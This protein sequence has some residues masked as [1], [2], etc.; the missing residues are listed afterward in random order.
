[1]KMYRDRIVRGMQAVAVLWALCAVGAAQTEVTGTCSGAAS[2]FNPCVSLEF[3]HPPEIALAETVVFAPVA[4]RGC[5]EAVVRSMSSQFAENSVEVIDSNALALEVAARGV[6]L[7]AFIDAPRAIEVAKILGPGVMLLVREDRCTTGQREYVETERRSRDASET[8]TLREDSRERT[9]SRTERSDSRTETTR[10]ESRTREE[11]AKEE[12][13]DTET[14]GEDTYEVR[15]YFAETEAFVRVSIQAV[16]LASGRIFPA[17]TLESSHSESNESE[18][19]VPRHPSENEVIELAAEQLARQTSPWFQP[20]QETRD[21]L[22]FDSDSKQCKLKAAARAFRRK[23]FELAFDLAKENVQA[24]MASSNRRFQSNAHYNLGAVHRA[25]E[26]YDLALE[27]FRTAIDLNPE[28]TIIRDAVAE[29]TATVRDR[30]ALAEPETLPRTTLP[31]NVSVSQPG[32]TPLV[33]SEPVVQQALSNAD[34]IELRKRGIPSVIIISRIKTATNW[35]FDLSATALDE[36][37]DAEVGEDVIT[38]M[39]EKDSQGPR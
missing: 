25:R 15:V 32:A 14:D 20:F 22:V 6:S 21:Y 26:E 18:R 31:L 1:M 9:S 17:K 39:M 2:A 34:V 3:E 7:G 33:A 11:E 38:A 23:N 37:L 24:C 30:E 8:E 29:T 19:R 16:D 12:D 27:S 5:A 28:R 35:S 36:L 10:R 13:E 4:G